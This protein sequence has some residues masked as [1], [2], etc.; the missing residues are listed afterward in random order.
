MLAVYILLTLAVLWV[1]FALTSAGI[2]SVVTV[3]LMIVLYNLHQV[4]QML[5]E[6][7]NTS[8]KAPPESTKKEQEE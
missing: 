4:K 7:K 6:I 1:D 2:H 8:Q 5:Q 3:L